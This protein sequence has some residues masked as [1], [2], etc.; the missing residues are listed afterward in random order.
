ML[1]RKLGLDSSPRVP[2]AR[3][4]NGTLYRDAVALQLLIVI[5]QPVVHIDQWRSHIAVGRVGVVRRELLVF[6]PAGGINGKRRLL[7]LGAK[8]A[9]LK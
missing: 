9:H 4:H 1:S 7:Q 8:S 2:I 3:Q 6:L 5:H